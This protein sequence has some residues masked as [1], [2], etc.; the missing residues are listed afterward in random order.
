MSAVC[1]PHHLYKHQGLCF[2][3]WYFLCWLSI[4]Y[5]SGNMFFIEVG[6][7]YF[8]LL[9]R[10]GEQGEWGKSDTKTKLCQILWEVETYIYHRPTRGFTFLVSNSSLSL[11]TNFLKHGI[12]G[13]SNRLIFANLF[14]FVIQAK[15][16]A[17]GLTDS[18][19]F[20]FHKNIEQ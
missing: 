12:E 19:D 3:R 4:F 10:R 7:T 2:T 9:F 1:L 11:E 18:W 8:T 15:K 6:N 17:G 14:V 5:F 20:H 16:V 13:D